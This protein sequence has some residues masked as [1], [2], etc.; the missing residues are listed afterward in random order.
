[1]RTITFCVG[2]FVALLGLPAVGEPPLELSPR[3]LE[4]KVLQP[5][6]GKATVQ[7]DTA[8]V[9]VVMWADEDGVRGKQI[10]NSR[11]ERGPI[12]FVVGAENI[13]PALNEGVLGMKPGGK[14]MLL[15]PPAFAYG[16]QGLPGLADA[17]SSFFVLVDLLD[18][19]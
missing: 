3:G 19:E 15:V 5:G 16:S 7:G 17:N 2:I 10:Y 6:A 18:N 1:M 4:F 12:S 9:H 14:R 11:A 8:Q 13:M